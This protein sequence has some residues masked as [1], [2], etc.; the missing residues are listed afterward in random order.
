MLWIFFLYSFLGWI[1]DS[2]YRSLAAHKWTRGGFSFLPL[3]PTY[4][5]GVTILLS[6]GH[7]L[8]ALPLFVQWCI[9]GVFF[10][11]YEYFCGQMAVIFLNRRLWDYSKSF[12][13]MHG[14]TN[15]LHAVYWATLAIFTLHWLH[16]FILRVAS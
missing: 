10:A 7:Y 13:N 8:L 15:L 9:L 16:P 11:G 4:G 14:H 2:C 12:L 3:A 6:L 1:I 5:L